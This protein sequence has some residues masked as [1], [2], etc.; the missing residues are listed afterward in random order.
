M[1]RNLG[2]SFKAVA[3]ASFGFSARAADSSGGAI[4][5]PSAVADYLLPVLLLAVVGLISWF[6]WERVIRSPTRGLRR[7]VGRARRFNEERRDMVFPTPVP[8][9]RPTDRVG[10]DNEARSS[11]TALDLTDDDLAILRSVPVGRGESV[12]TDTIGQDALARLA[13]LRNEPDEKN[14]VGDYFR[15]DAFVR[16]YLMERY[17]VKAFGVSVGE[18]LD[19]LPHDL[20]SGVADYTGEILRLCALAQ[21]RRF[22]PSRTELRRLYQLT[23][24]MILNDARQQMRDRSSNARF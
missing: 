3:W 14:P 9:M 10:F 8:E 24:A 2:I 22:R 13:R 23:E 17:H 1:S 5:R 16:R 18:L 15:L 12:V 6:V 19:S 4:S 21:L 11:E 20:T 7:A